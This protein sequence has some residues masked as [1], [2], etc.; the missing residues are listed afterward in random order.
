MAWKYVLHPNVL[1]FFGVSET[2]DSFCIINP[3][4]LNGNIVEYTKKSPRA[5]RLQLVSNTDLLHGETFAKLRPWQLAQAACGLKHLHSLSIV[6]GSVIPVGAGCF[7][8]LY[9]CRDPFYPRET[10]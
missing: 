5:N 2:F 6:H 1:P 3:W 7:P 4:L 9:T 10:F 8:D